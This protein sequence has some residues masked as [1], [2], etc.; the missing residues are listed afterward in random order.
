[1]GVSNSIYNNYYQAVY[2]AHLHAPIVGQRRSSN[3]LQVQKRNSGKDSVMTYMAIKGSAQTMKST[4]EEDRKKTEEILKQKGLISTEYDDNKNN[5]GSNSSENMQITN[6]LYN[7]VKFMEMAAFFFGYAGLGMVI[8][9]YELR[10]F[11]ENG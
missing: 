5:G 11:L 2:D 9:E 4:V 7:R 3:M 10:Y 1:M 8:I 6:D